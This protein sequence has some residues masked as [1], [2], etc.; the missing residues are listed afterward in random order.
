MQTNSVIISTHRSKF[1]S[2]HKVIT[3][4]LRL[5]TDNDLQKIRALEMYNLNNPTH[6]IYTSSEH[7]DEKDFLKNC[8]GEL[9]YFQK[10]VGKINFRNPF[11]N[12]NQKYDG[13]IYKYDK[14]K[15]LE[16]IRKLKNK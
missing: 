3:Y 1:L 13:Y 4:E 5:Y 6:I 7:N 11:N 12:E 2:R 14:D 15:V 10:N 16:C 9:L 8:R